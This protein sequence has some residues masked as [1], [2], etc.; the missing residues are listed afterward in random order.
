MEIVYIKNSGIIYS[1]KS[2]REASKQTIRKKNNLISGPARYE[3]GV[4]DAN[5]IQV[6][7]PN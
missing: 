3:K 5:R 6:F 1:N 7:M 2:S 4:S